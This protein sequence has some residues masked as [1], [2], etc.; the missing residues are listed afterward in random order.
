MCG[1]LRGIKFIVAPSMGLT[2]IFGYDSMNWSFFRKHLSKGMVIFDIGA[3]RGQMGLFFSR[4]VGPTGQVYCF[5]PMT[6]LAAEL[7]KN[8]DVN[9][10]RKSTRLNSSH[11]TISY[12]VFCLKKKKH[13]KI[14]ETAKK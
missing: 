9:E 3:N 5:E 6:H 1:P 11:I 8:L 4:E 10:D 12:A 2:F 7:K 13:S 14:M